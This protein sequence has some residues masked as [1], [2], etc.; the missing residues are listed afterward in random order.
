MTCLFCQ[1]PFK[2][3]T[4]EELLICID[5]IQNQVTHISENF[6]RALEAVKK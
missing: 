3:H 1:K 2:E 4:H 5:W 6:R